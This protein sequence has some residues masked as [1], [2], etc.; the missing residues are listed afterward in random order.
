MT[1]TASQPRI[2]STARVDASA[3]LHPS[4]QVG[5]YA[6]IEAGVSI[7]EGGVI[8]AHAQ[9][10]THTHI[11]KFVFVDHF[12]VLGADAQ[13]SAPCKG[14]L[15]IEDAVKI[16][17]GALIER[18]LASGEST[19]IGQS[20]YIMACAKVRSGASLGHGVCLTNAVDLGAYAQVE[21][22]VIIGG[23]TCIHKGV[24]IG[25]RAMVGSH[26]IITLHVP[27]FTLSSD[28]DRLCG[29]NAVGLKRNGFTLETMVDLRACY[30]A[31]YRTSGEYS[32][33]ARNA[34]EEGIFKTDAGERFL[35]FFTENQ[36]GSFIEPKT[37]TS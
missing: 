33:R 2:H 18:P 36:E 11:G 12:A 37:K 29:F 21:D 14:Q 23:G 19:H 16:R 20:S 30:R 28:Y 31:V 6:R 13:D 8:A 15:I 22:H 1:S 25:T 24:Q 3:Q 4:V 9:V 35:R 17:E 27:P 34:L 7:D 10:H 26:A 32:Q 5:P